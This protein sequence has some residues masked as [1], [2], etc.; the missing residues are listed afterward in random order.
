MTVALRDVAGRLGD[1]R[2]LMVAELEVAPGERVVLYGPNGAGKSTLLRMLAGT[3]P[4]AP[5]ARWEGAPAA[6]LPQRPYLFR[7]GAGWNMRL[8][9]DAGAAR[10]ATELADRLGV[11]GLAARPARALSGGERQRLALARVLA[12]PERLVLLDEPLAPLDARDRVGVARTVAAAIGDRAAVVV[13]HD[14]DEAAILGDRV[15]VMV[16]GVVRQVGTAAEVFALPVDDEVAAV[17]G[18]GNAVSGVLAATDGGLAAVR[19]G[20]LEIWGLGHGEEGAPGLALFGAEAVTVYAGAHDDPG[21]A[22][23]AWPGRVA[24][25]RPAGRLVEVLVDAG[26]R[27]AALVTPGSMEALGLEPG[28]PVTVAVK[29]TAVRIVRR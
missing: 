10:R 29:A 25:V 28:A 4:A 22:R 13:T 14:H 17:V 26:V 1:G 3:V 7:G 2:P 5:A 19:A 21:S 23:N 20:G 15:A 11:A 8:G 12:R 9:L 18:V 24:E 27:V 6:Y 16:D